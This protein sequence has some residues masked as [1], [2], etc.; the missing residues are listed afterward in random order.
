MNAVTAW[1]FSTWDL[2]HTCPLKYKFEK[3]DKLDKGPDPEAFKR[4]RKVHEHVAKYLAKEIPDLSTDMV[5][6]QL[7]ARTYAEFRQFDDVIVEK[8]W[9]FTR[10]WKPTGWFG[11]PAGATWLRT[12][13]DA[14]VLYEDMSA[15]IID[16]KTGKPRGTYGDQL[17]LFAVSAMC[18]LPAINHVTT[19]LQFVDVDKVEMADFPASDRDK[20]IAKWEKKV[21]PLFTDTAFNPRPGD[22]CRFCNFSRS[23]GGT[24]RFG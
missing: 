17:E 5:K 15:E 4:G 23:A 19:R 18:H 9:G 10:E 7:A 13:V 24:C 3:I 12:V 6:S 21:E 11:G 22:G 14:A 16:H 2:Y 20:L 1:S 8:Q